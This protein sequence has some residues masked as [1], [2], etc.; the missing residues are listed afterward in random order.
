M[1]NKVNIGYFFDALNILNI[2]NK[3][4]TT[5]WRLD[6]YGYWKKKKNIVPKIH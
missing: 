1:G 2:Y 5:W 6:T 3:K 4:W